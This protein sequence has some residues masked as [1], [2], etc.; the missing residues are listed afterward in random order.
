MVILTAII[1]AQEGKGDVVAEAFKKH[2]PEFQ[3]DPGTIMYA[4]QRKVDDPD[5]F[6]IYER[7]ENKAALDA[8]MASDRFK[9][10]G[11]ATNSVVTGR[12]EVVFYN[13]VA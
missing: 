5:T 9:E 1:K 2:A 6:L 12:P 7:Y 4:V 3:K 8:H 13:E 10:L 11:K